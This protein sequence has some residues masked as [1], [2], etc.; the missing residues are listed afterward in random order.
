MVEIS[1]QSHPWLFFFFLSF[2]LFCLF[3]KF[4][5]ALSCLRGVSNNKPKVAGPE[6]CCPHT[7]HPFETIN[8]SHLVYLQD[9]T[10]APPSSLIPDQNAAY[11]AARSL[12]LQVGP[13]KQIPGVSASCLGNSERQVTRVCQRRV[14]AATTVIPDWY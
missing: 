1:S 13:A 4:L 12:P 5:G 14:Q 6:H 8:L 7:D 9:A 10:A 11:M 3:L 2:F